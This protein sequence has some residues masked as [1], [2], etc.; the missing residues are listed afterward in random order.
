MDMSGALK[1]RLLYTVFDTALGTMGAV[2][3]SIGVLRIVLP[4]ASREDVVRTITDN[5]NEYEFCAVPHFGDLSER[6]Q[7]YVRGEHVEFSDPLDLAGSTPFQRAV[8]N[9]T[10]TIPYGKTQSYGWISNQLG[11]ERAARAVGQA[12]GS[13]PLPIIIPCHRVISSAGSLGGFTGGLDIKKRLL[14]IEGH[15][16]LAVE[17]SSETDSGHFERS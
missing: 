15:K 8:W 9:T 1:V 2:W 6:L 4:Q 13:N 11:K 10:R 5:G 16:D 17:H 14:A 3:S 12:L 7:R